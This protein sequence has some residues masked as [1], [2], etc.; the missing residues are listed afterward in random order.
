[1]EQAQLA[2]L[3]AVS[4]THLMAIAY[5]GVALLMIFFNIERFPSVIA[6]I[7]T[8]AFNFSSV[9][10]GLFGAAVM[11]GIKRGLYSLS[12]IHI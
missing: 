1:M 7:F 6:G 11:N 8:G 2:G 10:G 3:V 4:Y 12:L 5:I 9:A